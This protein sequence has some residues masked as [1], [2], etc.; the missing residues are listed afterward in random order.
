MAQQIEETKH[1]PI[2][3][4]TDF[5][6][7]QRINEIEQRISKIEELL[8]ILRND[9]KNLQETQSIKLAIQLHE[10]DKNWI[11]KPFKTDTK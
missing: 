4:S 5:S 6:N 3:E 1:E 9:I 7:E 2:H 10:E 11:G 8:I